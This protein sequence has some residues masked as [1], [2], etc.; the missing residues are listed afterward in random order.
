MAK[1]HMKR[2][3][4]PR[5]WPILRKAH[6]FI[7]RPRPGSQKLETGMSIASWL[8]EQLGIASN[9][10]EARAALRS[11]A[12]LVNTRTIRDPSRIVGL[13]DVISIPAQDAHYM[14]VFNTKNTL[15]PV[16]LKSYDKTKIS[17]ISAKRM[18]RG[19]KKQYTTMEGYTFTTDKD[20]TVGDTVRLDLEKMEISA[21]YPLKKGSRVYF[22]RGLSV[23]KY[24][25]IANE[26]STQEVEIEVDD[27]VVRTDKDVVIAVEGH[28]E[29]ALKTLHK[30]EESA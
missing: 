29:Q 30:Q 15:T 20:Y 26:I 23:G 14:I 27:K 28:L 3:A 19:A 18:V 22:I 11:G 4:A 25:T 17:R 9:A 5:T 21:T 8:T 1:A 12:V 10:R 7:R 16:P 2:I 13:F 24:G 6:T